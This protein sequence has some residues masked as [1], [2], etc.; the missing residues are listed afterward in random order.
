MAASCGRLGRG[1]RRSGFILRGN[2][3]VHRAPQNQHTPDGLLAHQ[4]AHL[5]VIDKL[6]KTQLTDGTQARS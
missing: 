3:E 2:L 6:R 5:G 1:P 4:I